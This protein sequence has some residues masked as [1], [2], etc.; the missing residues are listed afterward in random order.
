MLDF[1]KESDEILKLDAESTF[2]PR[3]VPHKTD[4]CVLTGISTRPILDDPNMVA[5][6]EQSLAICSLKG[7]EEEKTVDEEKTTEVPSIKDSLWQLA[8]ASKARSP[9]E[10]QV[11]IDESLYRK[12]EMLNIKH[13]KKVPTKY[14]VDAIL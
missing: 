13:G 12:I 9:K 6:M 5:S 10:K 11:R 1:L 4:T 2:Q 3:Y 14:F 7:S 8:D